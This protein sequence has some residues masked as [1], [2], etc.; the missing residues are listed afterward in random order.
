M[1]EVKPYIPAHLRQL[2][3]EGKQAH[4]AVL[5]EDDSYAEG[6]AQMPNYTAIDSAGQVLA[7]AGVWSPWEGR[8]VAHAILSS[9]SGRQ[10]T[11]IARAIVRYLDA[12]PFVR[13]E[14]DVQTDREECHR[15]A[16]LLGFE[17]ECTRRRFQ[18]DLDFDLYAR[19]RA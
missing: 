17:R 18:F 19:V 6:L 5:V 9:E 12:A 11:A 14:A 16:R 2:V 13:I 8:A 1:I 4:L 10:L 15:F 3:V 7:V